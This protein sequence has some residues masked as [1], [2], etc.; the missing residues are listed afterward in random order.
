MLTMILNKMHKLGIR[1]KAIMWFKYYVS[2]SA[3]SDSGKR[4]LDLT[5]KIPIC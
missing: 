5:S 4:I 2:E 3:E 1:G